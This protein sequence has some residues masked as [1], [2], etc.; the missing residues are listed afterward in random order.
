MPG[1]ARVGDIDTGH[2][3]FPPTAITAGSGDVFID[4]IAAARVG[5]PLQLHSCPC[6]KTPHGLHGR[7]VA[8]GSGTVKINGVAAAR[9]GDAVDCG[10]TIAVGSGT[11]IIG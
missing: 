7:S 2:G 1:A 4:G 8:A 11:V 10:G 3:C 6:P 9:L 5:D